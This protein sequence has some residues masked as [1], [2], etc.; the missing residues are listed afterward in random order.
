MES[1]PSIRFFEDSRGQRIAY[2]ANG[3]GPTLVCPAWWVSHLER[4]W[5]EPSFRSFFETL[6][7]RFTVVRY[8]R[9]GV[10]LSDR[11]RGPASLEAEYAL[12][13][14][15]I[16]RLDAPRVHLLGISCGGPVAI[17]FAARQP[18]RTQRLALYGTY[19]S[20]EEVGRP[21]VREAMVA[22]VRAHWGLG[23]STLMDVFLPGAD[24][25]SIDRYVARQ[26]V[27]ADSETAACLLDLTYE[28]DARG[29]AG[30][31]R[32]P[33]A[34]VHRRGDRAIPF[35]AGRR[36]AAAIPDAIFVPLEGRV[37]PPWAGGTDVA[38]VVARFLAGEDF[39]ET[40]AQAGAD[41]PGCRFDGDARAVVVDG[42]TVG[43]S[44]LEFGLMRHLLERRGA[45]VSRDDLLRDVWGQEF[46]GSNVV[47]AAVRSLRRKL[48]PYAGSIE[49]VKG[50][51]YRFRRFRS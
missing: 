14:E 37:H 48:G 29:N 6:G 22:L 7:Q 45:V 38:E 24:R 27:S 18:E 31:V 16:E 44:R 17:A 32:A 5:E 50:H 13:L 3:A 51:G 46:G 40:D 35:E 43:L 33:T 26:R 47:D 10:G 28:L 20:G 12:L 8:D 19:L 9:A 39:A 42:E 15:V 21:E 1:M 4:D 23:S 25:E 30:S 2:A 34:V 49:T 36:L 41:V 11:D